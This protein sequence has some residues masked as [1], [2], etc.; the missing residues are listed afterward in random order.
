MNK[1]LRREPPVGAPEGTVWFGG[2]VD[3]W[4]VALRVYAEDLDPDHVSAILG[5][6]PSSA[7]KKGDP[8]PR[9]G[10]WILTIDSREC[11]RNDDVEDGVRMLLA[12]LP[13]SLDVWA[14]LT[15]TYE[16]DV[17]CGLFLDSSNRGFGIQPDISK[18]LAER[19]LEIGFDIYSAPPQNVGSAG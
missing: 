14:S 2:P 12:R 1:V 11:D 15:S 18:S 5:C 8:F 9:Q 4:Q 7:A 19:G 3:S 13:S 10:R 6:Q 17:F 16:V